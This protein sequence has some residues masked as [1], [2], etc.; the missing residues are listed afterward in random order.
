MAVEKKVNPPFKLSPVMVIA[1]EDQ[2]L[3]RQELQQIRT[4]VFGKE[5]SGMGFVLLEATAGI[6]AILDECRT[7]GMF[8][9]KKLVVVSPADALFRKTTDRDAADAPA[10]DAVD[11]D[12][13]ST[14]GPEQGGAGA[15]RDMLLRYAQV[16]TDGATLVLMCNAW[17]ST[18]R[19]HKFLQPMGAIRWCEPI[20]VADAASWVARRSKSEYGKTIVP[21]A[22]NLLLELVGADLAR[23]DGELSKLALYD[24]KSDTITL[25][26]VSALV[27]FQH[28]QKV[29][30]LID[31]LTTGNAAAALTTHDELW[32]MDRKIG[33]SL[34]G[35]VFYWLA[36]VLRAREM[37]EQHVPEAEISKTLRLWQRSG[38]T[39]ALARQLGI[40]GCRRISAALLAADMGAKSSLG[41]HKR[42]MEV[43][44]VQLCARK[45]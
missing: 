41:E 16:P 3:R 20:G 39:L 12:D 44:I 33:Y 19:L 32:Q 28:E 5:P 15:A 21:A 35:A 11:A 23:L 45:G 9:P 40:A 18:T 27:G 30:A 43:F 26:M 13:E 6:T 31:A 38:P 24:L 2:F 42:N 17:L 25:E 22:V 1:G 37:L 29:W 4:A 34:V 14:D 7:V 36:Q 10:D 8:A